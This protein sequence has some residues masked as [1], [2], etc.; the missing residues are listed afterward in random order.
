MEA[1]FDTLKVAHDL[2]ESGFAR[3]QAEALASAIRSGQGDL[4]VKADLDAMESRWDAKL[5]AMESSWDTK[6]DAMESR[7]DA[8]S[9]ARESRWDAKLAALENRLTLRIIG[10]A[11]LIIA[12]VKLLPSL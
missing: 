12:A 3:K 10:I 8:K 11:G 1:A 4:V 2:E 6:L 9:A 7:W 5:T